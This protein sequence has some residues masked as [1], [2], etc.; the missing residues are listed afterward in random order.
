ML[1]RKFWWVPHYDVGVLASCS[2][3]CFGA[4]LVC[5]ASCRL[6]DA[7]CSTILSWTLVFVERRVHATSLPTAGGVTDSHNGDM[8]YFQVLANTALDLLS[9]S[10]RR[11]SFLRVLSAIVMVHTHMVHTHGPNH[12]LVSLQMGRVGCIGNHCHDKFIPLVVA[13][14]F[15]G[16]CGRQVSDRDSHETF[17]A[18]GQWWLLSLGSATTIAMAT[19]PSYRSRK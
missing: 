15:V 18:S 19:A 6:V 2:C 1:S 16:S 11:A 8:T 13:M 10:L 4:T 5:L 3:G 7:P 14:L 12:G 17:N 9:Q